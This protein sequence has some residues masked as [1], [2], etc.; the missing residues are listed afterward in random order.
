MNPNPIVI[1]GTVHLS[2]AVLEREALRLRQALSKAGSLLAEGQR[3]EPETVA[4]LLL[5][6]DGFLDAFL[7]NQAARRAD[8]VRRQTRKCV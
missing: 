8:L 4:S 1:N 6:V 3:P 2:H 5:E 7:R